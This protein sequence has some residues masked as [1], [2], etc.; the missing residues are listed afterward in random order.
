M[1]LK[2]FDIKFLC[3]H[4]TWTAEEATKFP[5]EESVKETIEALE[6]LGLGNVKKIVIDIEK[7]L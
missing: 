7:Y 6:G 3:E 4:G 1:K 5:T 2:K